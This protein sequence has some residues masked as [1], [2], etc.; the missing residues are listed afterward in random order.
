MPALQRAPTRDYRT[1]SADSH[2]WDGF[3]PRDD[4][5]LVAAYPKTGTTWMRRIIDLLVFQSAAVRPFNETSPMLETT[6]FGPAEPVLAMLDAQTHRRCLK[7]ELPFDALPVFEGVK[8]VHVVRDGRDVCW[9]MHNHV[10]GFTPE[11]QRHRALLAAQDPRFRVRFPDPPEDPRAFYLQWMADAER[12]ETE[13]Y[14]VDMPFFDVETTYWLERTRS[15]LLFVHYND[16]KADLAGEMRRLCDYLEIRVAEDLMP[17]LIH[18]ASFATM[19]GQAAEMMPN[20]HLVFDRGAER[21]VNQGMTGR[22]EGLLTTEDLARYDALVRRK[23]TPAQAAWV[24][25]G[26]AAGDPRSIDD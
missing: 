23:F 4:D 12:E 3:A 25:H 17:E 6:A 15:N 8:Y 16:L 21:F 20:A 2:R 18:A 26:S 24:Q 13:G 11:F 14:G 19:K 9:S 22:W 7:S 5:I 10:L 1:M